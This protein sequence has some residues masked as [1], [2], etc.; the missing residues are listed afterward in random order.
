MMFHH[1]FCTALI[2]AGLL[3]APLPALAAPPSPDATTVMLKKL[4]ERVERLEAE[5]AQQAQEIRA[6]RQEKE[7]VEQSVAAGSE[8]EIPTRLNAVEQ[9]VETLEKP[10]AFSEKLAEKLD[11]IAVNAALTTV[12][13]KANGLPHGTHSHADD[14]LSYR[15][16]LSVEVPLEPVG[17][18][19]QKLYAH[20]RIGQGQGLNEPLGYLGHL[21]VPNGA[22]FQ[23]SGASPDDSA[24]ILGEAWYQA[25]IPLGNSG[26]SASDARQKL[27]LTFGKMMVFNFFDQNEVAGDETTQFLN[28]AF[29]ANSLLDAGGEVGADANGFQPG[30]IASYLNERNDAEPWRLSLGVFGAGDTASNYQDTADSPM[31]IAQAEKTLKLFDGRTGNYRLYVWTRKDVPRFTDATSERHTG[32]GLSLDQQLSDG[33]KLFGRY[34]QLIS[35]KLPI[36]RV[37]ALGAEVSGSYWARADDVVG[38]GAGWLWASHAYRRVGGEGYLSKASYESGNP[39]FSFTPSGTERVAEI[40]YRFRVSPQ[41]SISPDVQWIQRGGANRD[42]DPVTVIGL[43]AN[44]VY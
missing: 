33:F 1:K 3:G 9:D 20:V 39:D 32:F 13:Q 44:V 27:E 22:A 37:L 43:R 30:V 21:S 12:W 16:D 14:K 34:G 5:N 18:I 24:L 7:A 19:E 23:A 31:V 42:A 41:L 40:Y 4:L 36:K 26:G 28:A 29:V 10:V 8:P 17:T 38:V 11:G 15:A 35:G 2:L 6:L 25:T